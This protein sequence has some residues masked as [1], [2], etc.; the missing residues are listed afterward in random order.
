[1]AAPHRIYLMWSVAR[2]GLNPVSLRAVVRR[3]R[4]VVGRLIRWLSAR[5][6]G[7]YAHVA[8]GSDGA[9]CS[10]NLGGVRYYPLLGYASFYPGV[11][12]ILAVSCERMPNLDRH[13]GKR[14]V[15]WRTLAWWVT[16]GLFPADNCVSVAVASCREAGLDI[17]RVVSPD[18]L[19]REIRKHDYTVVWSQEAL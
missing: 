3:P 10:I 4:W 19:L 15:A 2:P 11:S 16:G 17:G 18:G 7:H 8:V 5:L 1:M 13:N 12:H 6:C 9:V 14:L